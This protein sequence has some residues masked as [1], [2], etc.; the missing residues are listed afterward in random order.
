MRKPR[1]KIFE[2]RL[3]ITVNGVSKGFVKL[4]L[5]DGVGLDKVIDRAF[6][7]SKGRAHHVGGCLRITVEKKK[8]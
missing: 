4:E 1:Q 6:E 2:D 8:G 5:F 3:N 7:S